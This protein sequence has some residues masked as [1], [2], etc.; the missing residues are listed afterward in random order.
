MGL[1]SK[2]PKLPTVR[3][4]LPTIWPTERNADCG[5]GLDCVGEHWHNDEL[6]TILN[7]KSMW[8]GVA[9]LLPEPDNEHDP[10]AVGIY[11]NRMCVGYLPKDAPY[12]HLKFLA[13]LHNGIAAHGC[14]AIEADVIKSRNRKSDGVEETGDTIQV[15]LEAS[16][17]P[18]SRPAIAKVLIAAGFHAR[19]DGGPGFSVQEHGPQSKVFHAGSA[20]DNTQRRK[21][22]AEYV[23]A[24]KAAGYQAKST[25]EEVYGRAEYYNYC[26]VT[27]PPA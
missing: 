14:V 1:F 16:S 23:K 17:R 6:L 2:K 25:R 3:P 7:G 5:G 26:T 10:N 19:S 24:L 4:P 13:M 22:C 11:I 8:S 20:G 15:V 27:K 21:M 12:K 9:L 18:M